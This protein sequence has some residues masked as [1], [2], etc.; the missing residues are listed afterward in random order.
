MDRVPANEYNIKFLGID[1]D[2]LSNHEIISAINNIEGAFYD[3]E[4]NLIYTGIMDCFN[5]EKYFDLLKE[6]GVPS[7]SDLNDK[8][9]VIKDDEIRNELYYLGFLKILET[10]YNAKFKI[11]DKLLIENIS[12]SDKLKTPPISSNY[13]KFKENLAISCE[14]LIDDPLFDSENEYIVL[15]KDLEVERK[16]KIISSDINGIYVSSNYEPVFEEWEKNK[17]FAIGESFRKLVKELNQEKIFFFGCSFDNYKHNYEKRLKVFLE[18][19]YDATE[20]DF[21]QAEEEFLENILYDIQNSES[22]HDGYSVSGIDNF[23][24]AYDVISNMGYKQYF[25]S[26]NKKIEF[27]SLRN[28]RLNSIDLSDVEPIIGKINTS[29]INEESLNQEQNNI[30]KSTIEDYLEEFKD[31]INGNGY[32]KLVNTLFE[33]FTNGAFPILESKIN[34]KRINKKRVGWALKEIYKSEKTGNLEI[35]YFRFAQQNINLFAK[36]DIVVEDFN[37]SNFYKAFTTNPN[38]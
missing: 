38:K 26:H 35:D 3:R 30:L 13:K 25:F 7:L 14:N 20:V 22:A 27:L 18:N 31:Y 6:M 17:Y 8:L 29:I 4:N 33:Y 36:E 19:Y 1:Y 34:F 9:S 28:V 16:S 21:I 10:E 15:E 12:T 24:K 32:E 2:N 23:S 5:D 11:L 37:K